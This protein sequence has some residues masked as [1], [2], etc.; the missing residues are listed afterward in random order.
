MRIS[1]CSCQERSRLRK[2]TVKIVAAGKTAA[3]LE[4]PFSRKAKVRSLAVSHSRTR[5][6][7]APLLKLH[8][9][10][11]PAIFL[12][13]ARFFVDTL[14]MEVISYVGFNSRPA[15]GVLYAAAEH[16]TAVF[17]H[18][19]SGNYYR[20]I[21]SV[22]PSYRVASRAERKRR[23]RTERRTNSLQSAL[24]ASGAFS[25]FAERHT[26][27][28]LRVGIALLA[29]C[30]MSAGIITLADHAAHHTGALKLKQSE[31]NEIEILNKTM[32]T[33]ALDESAEYADDGTIL[34]PSGERIA[35][36]VPQL[37]QAVR[38]RTYTVQSGDT[39][40]GIT[41][42]FGL[43]NIST[44]IGVN[45]I[46]NVRQLSAG[47]QLK[48]PSLDGLLYT[49]KSGNSLAGL[50]AKFGI[51]LEDLLDVNDLDSE[52][53]AAGQ[54][55]F[56]P[57]ARLDSE[58]LQQALGTLFKIPI[59]TRYRITSPFGNRPDPF[60][61][62]KSFHTGVDLACPM[63][64]P[65][66][67]SS[68]GTVSFVG[69][70]NIFGNYVII[71]HSGGYQ[72]LYGHLSKILAAKGQWVSQ[73]TRVGLVGSTGYSTGPHLH[74]TVFKNGKLVDPMTLVKK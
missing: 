22:Q 61:G 35:A 5:K 58:R 53:L 71:K 63:G 41:K 67:A 42:K 68:S 1:G 4:R 50:S 19:K 40:S 57:G 43:K 36:A 34:T 51:T 64:T 72:T 31:S 29:L 26:A 13:C 73:G 28:V 21:F 47:Q 27:S 20:S 54:Q 60:T 18:R 45:D 62:L 44:L 74:F 17:R 46:D 55:L 24:R 2:C 70:S 10:A 30:G 7:A 16:F 48:I 38:Y 69:Y 49:V 32:Q 52:T 25:D 65:V 39:I 66:I 11:P 37:T 15:H 9:I 33:F 23:I 59:L 14:R 12:I 8:G 6:R 56:I 3:L